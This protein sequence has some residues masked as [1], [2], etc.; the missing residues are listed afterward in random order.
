MDPINYRIARYAVFLDTNVLYRSYLRD[1]VLRL[2][3]KDTFRVHWSDCVLEELRE[4]LTKNAGLSSENIN[5]IIE[6]MSIAFPDA[7]V[8]GDK[9]INP[10]IKLKDKD[11]IQIVAGAIF[12]RCD[13]ILTSNIDDFPKEILKPLGI[14]VQHPDE[15]LNHH[16]SL[17]RDITLETV[18]EHIKDMKKPP[19]SFDEYLECL[20]NAGLA[21]FPS[22]LKS[23]EGLVFN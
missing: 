14:D 6:Q 23:A 10:K 2:S 8:S 20:A 12:G 9:G 13:L 11:D 17:D 21:T 1:I 15:F 22:A 18:K 16:L 5:Y 4:A 3:A 7:L 19:L